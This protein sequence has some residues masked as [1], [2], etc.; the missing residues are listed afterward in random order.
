MQD[1]GLTEQNKLYK[2]KH[3]HKQ[4][5]IEYYVKVLAPSILYKLYYRYVFIIDMSRYKNILDFQTLIV[6]KKIFEKGFYISKEH[7][8]L[9]KRPLFIQKQNEGSWVL[10]WKSATFKVFSIKE[11]KMEKS[12]GTLH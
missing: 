1:Q 9:R 7:N 12:K 2:K 4:I 8:L 6:K 3:R 11:K 10:Q 5:Y